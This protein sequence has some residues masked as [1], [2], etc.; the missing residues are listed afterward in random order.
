MS[1]IEELVIRSGAD[2]GAKADVTE[3]GTLID[4][5]KPKCWKYST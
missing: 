4:T 1:K 2:D 3:P 5:L